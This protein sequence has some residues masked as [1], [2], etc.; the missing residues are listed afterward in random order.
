MLLILAILPIL[1]PM[2]SFNQRGGPTQQGQPGVYTC[3][4][5]VCSPYGCSDTGVELQC[6]NAMKQG[7]GKSTNRI[8]LGFFDRSY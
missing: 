5:S 7:F 2:A 3:A 6:V 8:N 4:Q 1:R